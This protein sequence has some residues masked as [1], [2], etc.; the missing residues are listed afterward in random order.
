MN[1]SPGGHGGGTCLGSPRRLCLHFRLYRFVRMTMSATI[2]ATPMQVP[3]IVP[4]MM[5]VSAF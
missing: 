2:H 3:D 1:S 5:G 4:A